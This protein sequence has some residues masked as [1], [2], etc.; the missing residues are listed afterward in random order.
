MNKLSAAK[1]A[2]IVR[3]LIEGNSVRATCRIVGTAKGTVLKLLAE[4]GEKCADYQRRTLVNLPSTKIQVDEIWSFVGCHERFVPRD[5]RGQGRGDTWTWTALCATTKL[6]P[7]WHVG[8]RDADAAFTFIEDLASR[9]ANRIQLTSDG[10][11]SYLEAVDNAFGSGVDY[12]MLVKLYGPSADPDHRYSPAECIATEKRPV[13]GNPD[14]AHISTSFVE[15]QN[16]TMRMRNRRFTR[17][18]NG[19]SKKLE[20]HIHAVALYTMAYN[21]VHVHHTL[22][23]AAKGIH[24]TPA[25][26]AGVT[27]RVWTVADIV[28]LLG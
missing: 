3:S 18:T 12:A 21:F 10:Y 27:D 16:L 4:L 9:L 20:N 7:S 5:E 17:L 23:K 1:R 24:T 26:A 11:H 14:P 2:A 19:Y 25:M 28:A 8:R 6:I 13:T 15:A 22:T